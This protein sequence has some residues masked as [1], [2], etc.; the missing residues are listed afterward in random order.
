MA[1]LRAGLPRLRTVETYAQG[2]DLATVGEFVRFKFRANLD[3]EY[4]KAVRDIW[5]GPLLVK[6]LLHPQDAESCIQLGVDGICVS[7]HGGRQFDGAP[8]AID[9]LPAV[10]RVA[11]GK[12]A[13]L[14]DSGLRS[15]LDIMRALARGADFV[16]LG[17]AYLYGVSALGKE[18]GA[19]TTEILMAELKNNMAQMGI[20]SAEEIKKLSLT[21]ELLS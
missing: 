13:L 14:F 15:G 10:A 5:Q 19:H 2:Q 7:N 16:L 18:G 1:T 17:R 3:W 4:L 12:T 20:Q 9:A 8:A 21:E 11:K 6:G